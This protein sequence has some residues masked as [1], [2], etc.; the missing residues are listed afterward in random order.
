ML[1]W[2]CAGSAVYRV[3]I[4]PAYLR[5]VVPRHAWDAT[6]GIAGGAAVLQG[7]EHGSGQVLGEGEQV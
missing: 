5:W 4:L 1:A 2:L 7:G 3:L 6:V